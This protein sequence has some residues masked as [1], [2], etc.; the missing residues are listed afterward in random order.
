VN[1]EDFDKIIEPFAGSCA[2]SLDLFY[3]GMKKKYIVN[4]ID[5]DHIC[6]LW[7]IKEHGTSKDLYEFVNANLN[8]E[9]WQR[10]RDS[11]NKDTYEHFYS[12]R[13]TSTFSRPNMPAEFK[14]YIPF[15]TVEMTDRFFTEAKIT[16]RD[17]RRCID[18]YKDDPRALIFL[19]P[20][21]FSSF[22]ATYIN[23]KTNDRTDMTEMYVE[24]LNYLKTARATI[25]MIINGCAILNHVYHDY[26]VK[27]YKKMYGSNHKVMGDDGT[28]NMKDDGSYIMKKNT[29]P[30]MVVLGGGNNNN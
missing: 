18:R 23:Y 14:Q 8:K 21:Y 20:P 30:H 17:W 27:R 24:I 19:D 22:N 29:S 26:I 16:N 7:H 9:T 12:K 4:D 25:I 15:K 10:I 2:L 6:M 3:R 11:N 13:V 1:Y 28:Y 5:K